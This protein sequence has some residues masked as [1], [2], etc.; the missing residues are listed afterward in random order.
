VLYWRIEFFNTLGESESFRHFAERLATMQPSNYILPPSQWQ[1]RLEECANRV[2]RWLQ[3][4][5]SKPEIHYARDWVIRSMQDVSNEIV[6][7]IILVLSSVDISSRGSTT[8]I[9]YLIKKATW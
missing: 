2:D 5:L 1:S 3:E 7:L 6:F 8:S 4:L 9:I